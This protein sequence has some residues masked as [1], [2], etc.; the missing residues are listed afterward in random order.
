MCVCTVGTKAPMGFRKECQVP[1]TGVMDGFKLLY[2]CWEPNP[3]SSSR[4]LSTLTSELSSLSYLFFYFL[5]CFLFV[6]LFL[7]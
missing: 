5:F 1:G 2:G 3:R 7:F 6:C 4:T